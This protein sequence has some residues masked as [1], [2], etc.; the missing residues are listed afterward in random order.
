MKF[1][2]IKLSDGLWLTTTDNLEKNDMLMHNNQVEHG[3][4]VGNSSSKKIE[5]MKLV[6]G[7]KVLSTELKSQWFKAVIKVPKAVTFVFHNEVIDEKDILFQIALQC[8]SADC[9][10]NKDTNTCEHSCER[11]LRVFIRNPKGDIIG[12]HA[13]LL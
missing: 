2:V 12:D 7:E 5:V 10:F 8:K 11:E 6:H 9:S 1:K 13:Y 4:F 3:F